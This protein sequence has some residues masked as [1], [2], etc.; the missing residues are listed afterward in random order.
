MT[1]RSVRAVTSIEGSTEISDGSTDTAAAGLAAKRRAAR[2]TTGRS[3]A[4]AVAEAEQ[5]TGA[6][7]IPA[8]PDPA[9]PGAVAPAAPTPVTLIADRSVVEGVAAA[10][11]GRA[12]VGGG[13]QTPPLVSEIGPVGAGLVVSGDF[14]YVVADCHADTVT[15]PPN[16]TT[17]VS[18][19]L[20]RAGQRVRRDLYDAVIAA[21]GP[22]AAIVTTPAAEPV[23]ADTATP[24]V[25]APA[26]A[27]DP[28][29]VHDGTNPG[30]V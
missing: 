8:A 28:V 14:D 7:G 21:Q 30:P 4:A 25:V 13:W 22:G 23:V 26:V 1:G 6:G 2:K 15:V 20:W 16:A 17:P 10:R 29:V 12:P 24:P 18:T 19:Q 5:G 9:Q 3:M 27:V 11:G